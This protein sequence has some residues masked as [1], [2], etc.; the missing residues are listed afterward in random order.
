MLGSLMILV[1]TAHLIIPKIICN[2]ECY[3]LRFGDLSINV[4]RSRFAGVQG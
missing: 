4:Q 1:C 3:S 2:I